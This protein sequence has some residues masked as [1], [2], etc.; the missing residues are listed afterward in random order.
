MA[1]EMDVKLIPCQM[2][3][4]LL[5]LKREDLV[6]GLDEPAGATTVLAPAQGVGCHYLVHMMAKTQRG[7]S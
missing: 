1:K 4:E 7:I 5:G 3:M 6:D 2:T